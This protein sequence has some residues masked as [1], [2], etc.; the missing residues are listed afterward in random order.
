MKRILASLLV[1]VSFALVLVVPV[2]S[3]TSRG[4]VI[5]SDSHG[6]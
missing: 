3:G 4:I 1:V 6:G 2:H 5:L